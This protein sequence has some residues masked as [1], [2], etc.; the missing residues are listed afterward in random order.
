MQDGR[1]ASYG[2]F[3]DVRDVAHA[4]IQAF[5]IPSATGRYCMVESVVDVT[6]LWR[7][8]HRLF[9]VFHLNEKYDKLIQKV[10]QISKEK[11]KSLGV[12]FIPL[13]ES[14]KDIVECLKEKG[15]ISF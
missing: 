10:F 7:I 8:L 11:I 5:E 12:N 6:K 15:F 4:H 1:S 13:E 9:H 14:L 3:M 2:V